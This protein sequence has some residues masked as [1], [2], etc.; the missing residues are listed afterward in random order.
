MIISL[1]DYTP[2]ISQ[3]DFIAPNATISGNVTLGKHASVWFGAVIR[4]E[5]EPIVI[6]DD[7]NIQ[8]NVT[9]HIDVNYP[10]HIGKRVTIGHNA[11][12][13]GC[14]IEDDVLVGMGATIL[15]GAHIGKGA[16]VAAGALVLEGME[17]PPN[18]LVAGVPAKV[19]KIFT[20]EEVKKRQDY[21]INLYLREGQEYAATLGSG[22]V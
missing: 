3:A 22:V 13:H 9:V 5:R 1:P 2:D 20:P 19:K 14:T 18:S 4:A 12:V 10:T 7:T 11:L 6:G 15:N 8:D 21:Y 16:L 17:V